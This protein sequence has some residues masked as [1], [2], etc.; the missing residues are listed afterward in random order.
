MLDV[1]LIVRPCSSDHLELGRLTLGILRYPL[2][3]GVFV[4]ECLPE[5]LDSLG[6]LLA[7]L[8]K[9]SQIVLRD[10]EQLVLQSAPTH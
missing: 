6:I 5:V 7:N 8:V 3:V 1:V 9:L 10:G 2:G 4:L